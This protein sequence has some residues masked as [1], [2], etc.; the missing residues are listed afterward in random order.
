MGDSRSHLL[1]GRGFDALEASAG[2]HDVSMA[3][4]PGLWAIQHGPNDD[5]LRAI[6]EQGILG[7]ALTVLWLGGSVLVGV[8]TCLRLPRGSHARVVLAGLTSATAAYIVA[9]TG[10]D[11]AHNTADLSIAA[12][13]TGIL[14]SAS[15]MSIGEKL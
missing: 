2:E 12:L 13:M 6:L 10:H 5:Y 3:I 7:L 15:T 11:F 14:V 1:F 4:H 8:S 9:A